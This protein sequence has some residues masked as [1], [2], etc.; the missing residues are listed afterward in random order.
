MQP[1]A[2]WLQLSTNEVVKMSLLRHSIEINCSIEAAFELCLD[3]ENW[4]KYF[5]PCKKAKIF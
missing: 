5:P 3:V 1:G 4:P 2:E